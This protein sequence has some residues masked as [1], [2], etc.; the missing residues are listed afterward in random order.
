MALIIGYLAR[1]ASTPEKETERLFHAETQIRF[2]TMED[3]EREVDQSMK[4]QE[5]GIRS[6]IQAIE[7]IGLAAPAVTLRIMP[8]VNDHRK[9]LSGTLPAVASRD[10]DLP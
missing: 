4:A 6:F 1:L 10:I 3:F 7:K 5:Q 8:E 9:S 2:T